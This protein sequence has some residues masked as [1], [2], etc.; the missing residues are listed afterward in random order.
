MF[1]MGYEM[2]ST[3]SLRDTLA[4]VT[5]ESKY[6]RGSQEDSQE[7]LI[8]VLDQLGK[9]LWNNIKGKTLL[10]KFCGKEAFLRKFT[11]PRS[12]F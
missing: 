5:G 12:V 6:N 3:C 2:N 4:V 8:T 7:F 1:R 9:E 10:K 11:Y